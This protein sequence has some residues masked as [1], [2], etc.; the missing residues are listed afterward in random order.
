M[1]IHELEQEL[2][3]RTEQN[4][5]LYAKLCN[6]LMQLEEANKLIKDYW[7]EYPVVVKDYLEK[8][9]VK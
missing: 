8:W 9:G 5:E 1:D 3:I 4:A 7:D 2:Q 6:A